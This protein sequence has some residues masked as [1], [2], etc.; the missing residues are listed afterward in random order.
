M[1]TPKRYPNN[2]ARQRAYRARLTNEQQLL[3]RC[4]PVT[5]PPAPAISNVPATRR[6]QALRQRSSEALQTLRQE[7]QAYYEDRSEAWQ[8]G[9]KAEQFQERIDQL[10]EVLDALQDLQL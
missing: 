9:E 7:M 6:W 4:H 8:Q 3:R 5:L 1:P 2:A 10:E